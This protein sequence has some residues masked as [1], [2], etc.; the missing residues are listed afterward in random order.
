MRLDI[1]TCLKVVVDFQEDSNPIQK[2]GRQVMIRLMQIFC[3]TKGQ[4]LAHG[5]WIVQIGRYLRG[6][7]KR[8]IE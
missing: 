2:A 3:G 8:T 1:S 7:L 6:E 5:I 4:E